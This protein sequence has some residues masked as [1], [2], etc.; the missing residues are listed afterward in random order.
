MSEYL[1]LANTQNTQLIVTSHE[2]RLL[3]VDILRRD[4]INFTVKASSGAT[5]INPLEKYHLRPDKKVYNALFNGEIEKMKEL[6]PQYDESIL[7]A[8]L[9][10]ISQ[11]ESHHHTD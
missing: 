10:N 11:L 1:K 7:N 3:D 5:I 6:M 4:E 2:A 9:M 8:Y